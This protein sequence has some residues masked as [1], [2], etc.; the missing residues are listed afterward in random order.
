MHAVLPKEQ[1]D[2]RHVWAGRSCW[3][4][5][6]AQ[7]QRGQAQRWGLLDSVL[8]CADALVK[9]QTRPASCPTSTECVERCLSRSV[10][11]W[12]GSSK[13]LQL[14]CLKSL[15]HLI[16]FENLTF[17]MLLPATECITWGKIITEKKVF[18]FDLF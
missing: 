10:S 13:D 6:P 7:G 2:F 16:T 4:L 5:C 8:D 11:I 1:C 3:A 9:P 14:M 17:E 12:E 15:Y 18:S